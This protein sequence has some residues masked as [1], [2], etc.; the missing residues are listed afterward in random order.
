VWFGLTGGVESVERGSFWALRN[1]R[2]GLFVD[3]PFFS[4]VET[5]SG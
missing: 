3:V 5:R 2:T 4:D 1:V